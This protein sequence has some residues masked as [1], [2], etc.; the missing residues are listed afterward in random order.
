M[1]TEPLS[2]LI[3]PLNACT[4]VQQRRTGHWQQE[5]SCLPCTRL[6]QLAH[7]NSDLFGVIELPGHIL[8]YMQLL[9]IQCSQLLA[10]LTFDA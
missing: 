10:T 6:R 9:Q 4:L 8:V 2:K 5:Y 3:N 7:V 1:A